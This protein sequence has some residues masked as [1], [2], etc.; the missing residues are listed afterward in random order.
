MKTFQELKTEVYKKTGGHCGYCGKEFELDSKWHVEHMQPKSKNGKMI[1]DNLIPS[2]VTC[3]CK[4]HNRN[5]QEFKALLISKTINFIR[6]A[7]NESL[8]KILIYLD[9]DDSKKIT[10]SCFA[11]LEEINHL[12]LKFYYEVN[13]HG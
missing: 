3:N 12:N 1:I 5:P 4:K 6:Y 11:L 8:P 9:D 7:M 10:D 2:C 13:K